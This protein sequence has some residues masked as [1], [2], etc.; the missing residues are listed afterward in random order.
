MIAAFKRIFGIPAA[1]VA[2]GRVKSMASRPGMFLPESQIPPD[3]IEAVADDGSCWEP[4]RVD[5]GTGEQ[6]YRRLST[7]EPIADSAVHGIAVDDDDDAT[8][9]PTRRYPRYFDEDGVERIDV[10]ATHQLVR[11]LN[12]RSE[13]LNDEGGDDESD[14]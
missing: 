6:W 11:Q 14:E 9:E 5:P 1:P 8:D 13:I 3:G 2:G 12:R 4:W 10:Q 7:V